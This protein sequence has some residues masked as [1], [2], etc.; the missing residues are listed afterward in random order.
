MRKLVTIQRV[1]SLTPIPD[2]DRIELAQVLNWNVVV[3]KGLYTEGDLVAYHEIDS[4][5]PN[6]IP[7]YQELIA[8]SSRQYEGQTVHVL[9]TMKLRG[10]YSQGF[11]IP[12]D[13][14]FTVDGNCVTAIHS[15]QSIT[16]EDLIGTDVSELLGVI[17]YEKPI[18]AS[19]AGLVKGNFPSEIPKTDEERV[20]NIDSSTIIG[21]NTPYEVS[22]KLDGSSMTTGLRLDGEFIVC[23]RNLQLKL[24]QEG[25]SFVD[26]A[27]QYDLERKMTEF[28]MNGIII[29]GELM[30]P[31]IQGNQEK[32]KAPDFFVYKM[33]DINTGAYLDAE[34]RYNICSKLGLKHV[35]ILNSVATLP[36]LGLNSIEDILEFADGESMT[37]GVKREGLVFK[38]IDGSMSFKAISNKW[39]MKNQD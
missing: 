5:L 26:V 29:Q 16:T 38:A 21:I 39:L 25:N 20:Q 27:K 10:V 24:E 18:P 28:G 37:K 19:L 9:K 22:I 2:A 36:E 6:T 23:S 15:G 32:L 33:Y 31:G 30:G 13:K 7:S 8:K 1:N 35:P 17:K 4:A 34:S 12:F 3:Q 11:C 14:L